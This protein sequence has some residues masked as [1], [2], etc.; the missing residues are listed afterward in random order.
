MTALSAQE[1]PC[2]DSKIYQVD[3]SSGLKLRASNGLSSKVITLVPPQAYVE[4]CPCEEVLSLINGVEGCWVMAQFRGINGYLFNGYLKPTAISVELVGEYIQSKDRASADKYY[5]VR[6]V[7]K[8]GYFSKYE[9]AVFDQKKYIANDSLSLDH[10]KIYEDDVLF[11]ISGL[12]FDQ[13]STLGNQ[14]DGKFLY[15]GEVVRL[16]NDVLLFASGVP[17]RDEANSD[18]PFSFIE[19]YRVSMRSSVKEVITEQTIFESTACFVYTNNPN[20]VGLHLIWTGDL[21]NDNR[22]DLLVQVN[23]HLRLYLTNQESNG[24]FSL[25]LAY[26]RTLM[27]Y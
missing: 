7:E 17:K 21:N 8:R 16:D 4:V 27:S 26:K 13:E 12:A 22:P 25:D 18:R 3:T 2:P 1:M 14:Y 9:I 24:K 6:Y 19:D 5:S 15:P 23:D 10:R 20:P 11:V